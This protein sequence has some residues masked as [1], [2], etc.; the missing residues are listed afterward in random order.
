ME[1]YVFKIGYRLLQAL[2]LFLAG[3]GDDLLNFL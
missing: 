3:I 2:L 1:R